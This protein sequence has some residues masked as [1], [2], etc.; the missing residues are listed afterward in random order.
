MPIPGNGPIAP[1]IP[2]ASATARDI[3]TRPC[4]ISRP[5][6]STPG[7][8][9]LGAFSLYESVPRQLS[10][11]DRSAAP[12][13]AQERARA[14]LGP[15]AS[16]REGAVYAG[17]NPDQ[18]A[19]GDVR[20]TWRSAP[21]GAISVVGR[22]TQSALSPY[23]ASNG[24]ELLL[25]EPGVVDASL[26]FKHG[27]EENSLLTW[28]LRA[29]G[30]IVMFIGCRVMLSL[31]EVLADLIPFLGTIVGAGASFLALICTLV[32]AP[33]IVAIAWIFY[34]PMVAAAALVIG[35]ALVY[36]VRMLAVRQ[37]ASVA[38]PAAA[39]PAWR[40]GAS[41]RQPR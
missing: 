35:A 40:T 11:S 15:R 6:R 37:A 34:R 20:V 10:A 26:M 38:R 18:P 17:A 9:K 39:P 21:V 24:R 31:L 16:I 23:L 30:V 32:L 8:A 28:V 4:L 22:Q 41:G 12:A 19:V 36:G 7:E 33:L 1:L 2:A 25:A 27:E 5:V 3:E 13:T 29:V 14:L